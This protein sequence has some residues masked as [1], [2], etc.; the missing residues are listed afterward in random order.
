MLAN[1]SAVLNRVTQS[2]VWVPVA[3]WFAVLA[4]TL[5][6]VTKYVWPES[7][8]VPWA[9]AIGRIA[10]SVFAGMVA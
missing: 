4:M 5:E 2:S 7:A 10:F 9:L 8:F 3:Q 1:S 6:H